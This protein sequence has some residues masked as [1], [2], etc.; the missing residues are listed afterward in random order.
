MA[1]HQVAQHF[2]VCNGYT[3]RISETDSAT[4]RESIPVV[5]SE[6]KTI[7]VSCSQPLRSYAS[8]ISPTSVKAAGANSTY[9]L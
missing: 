7:A 5:R 9:T 6:L 4:D 2:A 8:R 1:A 3:L